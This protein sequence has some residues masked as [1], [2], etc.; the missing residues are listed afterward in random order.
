MSDSPWIILQRQSPFTPEAL[1]KALQALV[2]ILPDISKAM[3]ERFANAP[4]PFDPSVH[5]E[6]GQSEK[7]ELINATTCGTPAGFVVVPTAVAAVQVTGKEDLD[8]GSRNDEDINDN[9]SNSN[10]GYSQT[11]M[12][13]YPAPTAIQ[14][15]GAGLSQSSP[16]RCVF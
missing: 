1:D 15:E 6:S 5:F 4:A 8:L 9:S 7:S 11:T 10:N 12:N 16:L 2:I 3:E 14:L 13:Q